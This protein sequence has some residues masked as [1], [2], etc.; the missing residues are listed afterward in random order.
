M[1]IKLTSEQRA[2]VDWYRAEMEKA[3]DNA[4]HGEIFF[5]N[6]EGLVC[7]L[8]RRISKRRLVW[9]HDHATNAFRGYICHRCNV[10]LGLV[11][12]DAE[13][14]LRMIAYLDL[15]RA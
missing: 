15:K 14:L 8:C 7:P 1:A 5:S 10:A 11:D 13:T 2:K 4:D 9:D 3:R 6:S 12:D